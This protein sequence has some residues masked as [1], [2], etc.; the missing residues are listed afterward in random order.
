[1]TLTIAAASHAPSGAPDSYQAVEDLI[2]TVGIPGVLANDS[3]PDGR[4]LTAVLVRGPLHGQLTK[5]AT[6]GSFK[7]K[8]SPDYNGDDS[9]VYRAVAGGAQ[10]ADTIVTLTVAPV[11]DAPVAADDIYL[12]DQQHTLNAA[13]P[14]VLANDADV[15]GDP[16]TAVLVTRPVHGKVTLRADGSF[17]Y[18]SNSTFDGADSFTYKASDGAKK[19]AVATVFITGHTS[20]P[21]FVAQPDDY[22]VAAGATL[23][24]G[25]P[26]VLANDLDPDG[27][28]LIAVLSTTTAHGTLALA[29]D[30]S[31]TYTPNAGFTGTDTFIY[32]AMDTVDA[33]TPPTIVTI[34]VQ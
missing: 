10:S 7:Y 18:T 31:F 4:T 1:M 13:A 32:R 34:R 24:V 21:G 16:L 28:S 19:S 29:A 15:D 26:G 5:F 11:N 14:G 3:D 30:G 33:F 8:P 23:T 20:H 22:T 17:T 6:N 12:N 25:A 9:F 2:L 27:E